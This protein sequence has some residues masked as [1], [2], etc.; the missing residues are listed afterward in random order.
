MQSVRVDDICL[1]ALYD[2]NNPGSN[3]NETLHRLGL[4]E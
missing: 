1:D 2:E 4:A 3:E